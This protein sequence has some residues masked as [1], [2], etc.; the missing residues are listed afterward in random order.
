MVREA[1]CTHRFWVPA[2]TKNRTY[3]TNVSAEDQKLKVYAREN[4]LS[5]YP[6]CHD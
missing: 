6:P 5:V 4:G 2:W 1:G 3:Y